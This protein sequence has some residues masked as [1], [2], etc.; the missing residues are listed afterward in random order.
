MSYIAIKIV[1]L[2]MLSLIFFRGEHAINRMSS[3]CPAVVRIAFLLVAVGSASLIA[4]IVG[5][6]YVSPSMAITLSGIAMLMLFDRRIY[7]KIVA[8]GRL[9]NRHNLSK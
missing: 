6:M 4:A 3:G 8:R 9:H 1:C 7:R 5:G 2:I